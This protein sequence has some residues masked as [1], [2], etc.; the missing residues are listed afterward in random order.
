ML[1][2]YK[3]LG[4]YI[5]GLGPDEHK[6]QKEKKLTLSVVN[7]RASWKGS[8]ADLKCIPDR[9]DRNG[10]RWYFLFGVTVGRGEGGESGKNCE[11]GQ[12]RNSF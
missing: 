4:K 8:L 11:T 3:L 10:G 12:K 9:L 1:F 2:S 6:Y 7:V 5:S